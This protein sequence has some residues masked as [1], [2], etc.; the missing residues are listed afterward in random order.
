MPH[1]KSGGICD[2]LL[3]V[4]GPMQVLVISQQA[5]IDARNLH[6]FYCLV[7]FQ[8][9]DSKMRP[10]IQTTVCSLVSQI[11]KIVDVGV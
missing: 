1:T 8:K 9:L 7:T 3:S 2:F 5:Y 6:A 11:I 10:T 4:G